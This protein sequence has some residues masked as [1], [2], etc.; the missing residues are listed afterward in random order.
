VCERESERERER[1]R[2]G[3]EVQGRVVFGTRNE[4]TQ[5][6]RRFKRKEELVRNQGLKMGSGRKLAENIF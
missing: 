4:I 2:E 3:E 6:G 5:Y 1:A